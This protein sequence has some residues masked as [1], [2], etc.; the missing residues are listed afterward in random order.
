[1]SRLPRRGGAPA[2][3]TVPEVSG[4]RPRI[5]RSRLVLPDPLAPEHRQELTVGDVQ[6]DSRDHSVRSP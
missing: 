5:T 2:T 4:C 6:I 3:V 1:M